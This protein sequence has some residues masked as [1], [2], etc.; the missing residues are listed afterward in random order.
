MRVY[1]TNLRARKPISEVNESVPV[2]SAP[3]FKEKRCALRYRLS[4]PVSRVIDQSASTFRWEDGLGRTRI[5]FHPLRPV[6]VVEAQ[7]LSLPWCISKPYDPWTWSLVRRAGLKPL[8]HT[9]SS[10]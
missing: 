10:K 3:H 8:K 6:S 1:Y 7:S 9:L 5:L 2:A 4:D